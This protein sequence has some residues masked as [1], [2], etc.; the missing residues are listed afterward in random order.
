MSSDFLLANASIL[1]GSGSE[2]R[3]GSVFVPGGRIGRIRY[4]DSRE[5]VDEPAGLHVMDLAGAYL[6]PGFI[7]VHT[8]SDLHI[9]HSPEATSTIAQGVTT[10]IIGNCGFSPFPY[11]YSGRRMISTEI[12]ST[13][14]E[15]TWKDLHGYADAVHERGAAVNLV[16]L[17]GHGQLRSVAC[18]YD[19]GPPGPEALSDMRQH[20]QRAVDQGA[21]GLSSGLEYAPGAFADVDELADIACGFRRAGG[22]YATHMRDEGEFLLEAVREA[23]AV[24]ERAEVKLQI[25]HLKASGRPYWGRTEQALDL[26]EDAAGRGL[27]VAFDRYPYTAVSTH[28]AIFLPTELWEGGR[29]ELLRRLRDERPRWENHIKARVEQRS[30]FSDV[31]V[32]DSGSADRSYQGKNLDRI[33]TDMGVP[34]EKA[35]LEILLESEGRAAIACFSM[36]EEETARIL[37]HPRCFIGSDGSVHAPAGPLSQLCPHP[38]SYGTIPR[39]LGHY[40]RDRRLIELPEAIRKMTSAPARHFGLG[41]RGTIAEGAV[42]DL[43]AFRLEDI[44]D[45]SDYGAPHQPA[46]GFSHVW[47]GGTATVA[48]GK[49]TGALPGQVLL[50]G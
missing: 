2:P 22:L 30:G 48:D 24:A 32:T 50:R 6:A 35:A 33:A 7:D 20:T 25:S 45:P 41:G 39:F 37:A 18:G 42:A 17:L 31:I 34:P 40:V 3:S 13:R 11:S 1:D 47:V 27:Q 12:S 43:V 38:R 9:L 23:I 26:I 49:S 21:W 44:D 46:R 15:I 10:E 36:D 28:L 29:A 14:T 4:D 5:P 8:H 16:P 19:P